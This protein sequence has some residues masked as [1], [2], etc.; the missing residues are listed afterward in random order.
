M[1]GGAVCPPSP[2]WKGLD[3]KVTLAGKAPAPG[4]PPAKPS[5]QAVTSLTRSRTSLAARRVNLETSSQCPHSHL[6]DPGTC[7]LSTHQGPSQS[8]KLALPG[9]LLPKASRGPSPPFR[10]ACPP[11]P[12]GARSSGASVPAVH[13]PMGASQAAPHSSDTYVFLFLSLHDTEALDSSAIL[14]P[15]GPRG[16]VQPRLWDVWCHPRHTGGM[17]ARSGEGQTEVRL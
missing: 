8:P 9:G 10:G 13:V 16:L 14:I 5:P 17:G 15:C 1:A 7:F 12:A 3:R 11:H 2:L 6:P 4:S